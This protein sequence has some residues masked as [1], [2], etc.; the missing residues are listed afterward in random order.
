[1]NPMNNH[2]LA[3]FGTIPKEFDDYHDLCIQWIFL[4]VVNGLLGAAGFYLFV[5]TC[6]WCMWK[7]KKKATSLADEW[8]CWSLMSILIAS[9]FAMQLVALF[10]EMFFIYH[11]F[12]GLIA[13]TLV[14]CGSEQTERHVGVLAEMDG[15]QVLLRYRLKPGQRLAI[16]RPGTS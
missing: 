2:W 5:A 4:T 1:M 7:A 15:K 12:L 14:I 8:L 3:G 9:L 10:A 11:L 6:A 16:I 13:N